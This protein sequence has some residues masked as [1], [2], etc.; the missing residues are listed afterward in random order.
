VRKFRQTLERDFSAAVLARPGATPQRE[1]LLNRALYYLDALRPFLGR[2]P[3]L[4]KALTDAY[5]SVGVLSEPLFR[6]LAVTAFHDAAAALS[7]LAGGDPAQGPYREQWLFLGEK[8]RGLGETMPAFAEAQTSPAPPRARDNAQ[9]VTPRR[10]APNNTEPAAP[11]ADAPQS[12]A[13]TDAAVLE[14]VRVRLI[15]VAAKAKTAEEMFDDLRQSARRQGYSLHPNT[16]EAYNG[17]QAAMEEARRDLDLGRADAAREQIDIAEALAKRV[18]K[19][20][21]Q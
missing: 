13:A 2:N 5:Q 11:A 1:A 16:T 10:A 8:L 3:D 15:Q 18:L 20:G 7:A 21:G 6:D 14:Q 12:A 17:M 4:A 19:A 9:A